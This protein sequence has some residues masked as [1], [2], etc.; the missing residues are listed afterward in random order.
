MKSIRA[1]SIVRRYFKVSL[2]VGRDF[3]PRLCLSRRSPR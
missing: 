3:V 2:T 1:S